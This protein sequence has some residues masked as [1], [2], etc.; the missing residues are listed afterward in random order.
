[1][2][3][4]TTLNAKN[5]A[6]L[7]ADRLAELM[8]ELAAG[9]AAFKRRLRLE[10]AAAQGSSDVARE[11]SKRLAAIAKARAFVEWPK[12]KELVADLR[13]Q[14]QMITEQVFKIDAARALDLMWQFIALANPVFRRCDD[15][16]GVIGEIF[17]GAIQDLGHLA[18]E[19]RPTPEALARKVYDALIENHFG[20]YDELIPALASVLG[21]Q[22]LKLLKARFV[23]LSKAPT[24]KPA[25]SERK[26]VGWGN[27]GAIYK[28][29]IQERHRKSTV[30]LALQDIADALGDVDGFIAQHSEQ[31]RTSPAIAADIAKR[32]LTAGRVD[33]AWTAINGVKE[34]QSRWLPFEWEETRIAVLE[35]LGRADEAQA[36]RWACFERSLNDAHLRS[37][38]K[39][40]PDFD[41]IEAEERALNFVLNSEDQLRALHFLTAWPSL[42]NAAKLVMRHVGKWDGN[43]YEYMTPA[44]ESLEA[45]HPLAATILRRAMI[46]Y[47]LKSAKSTRYRHAARHLLECGSLAPVIGDFGPITPHEAYVLELKAQ[48]GRKAGF[49]EH[50][51]A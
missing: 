3:A 8:M 25:D 30:R 13:L 32:L 48:H 45:K 4:K 21:R 47:T 39:R 29:E 2:S 5:L 41:D 42:D 28:D 19:V 11:V 6:N 23:E 15:S 16:N 43:R 10:L 46:D 20:Q 27:S 26:V 1:M 51:V 7:G 9:D 18:K 33:E 37:Y 35:A 17:H 36:F 12:T 22:G 50:V 31:T 34:E 49:W 24:P 40:L 44:A 38:L 14:R